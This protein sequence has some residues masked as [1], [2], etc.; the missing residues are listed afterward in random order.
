MKN[1]T[2]TFVQFANPTSNNLDLTNHTVENRENTTTIMEKKERKKEK[3][4]NKSTPTLS[5][6]FYAIFLGEDWQ[7][8]K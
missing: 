7:I 5:E 1:K 8:L 3:G 4:C 6:I 2:K